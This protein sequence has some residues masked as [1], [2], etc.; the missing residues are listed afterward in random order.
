MIKPL[1]HSSLRNDG[2]GFFSLVATDTFQFATINAMS[3]YH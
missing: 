2:P 1:P 3:Y